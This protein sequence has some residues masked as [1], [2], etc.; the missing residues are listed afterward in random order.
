MET[1]SYGQTEDTEL[2]AAVG[3]SQTQILERSLSE[4]ELEDPRV[5]AERPHGSLF[6][7]G[8]R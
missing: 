5:K 8:D 4:S 1:S 3:P 6:H 2:Q 7:L